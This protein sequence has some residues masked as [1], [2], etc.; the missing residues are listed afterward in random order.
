MKEKIR[1]LLVDDQEL[2]RHRLQSILEP[3]EDMRVVGDCTTAEEVFCETAR[4]R[5]D[6]IVM[7]IQMLG[8]NG[9]EA[10]RHLKRGRLDYDA[11]IIILAESVNYRVEALKAGAASYLLMDKTHAELAR[12]IRDVYWRKRT[13]E[14]RERLEETVELVISPAGKAAR[15]L[16]FICQLEERLNDNCDCA[17]IMHTVGSWNRVS[18]ITI[19]LGKNPPEN[20]LEGLANMADVEKV[21]GEPLA[22]DIFSSHPRQFGTLPRSS[23]SSSKKIHV[24]LK[25]TGTP[26]TDIRDSAQAQWSVV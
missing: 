15:L 11:D 23:I 7:D 8:M 26:S 18:A 2:V 16:R 12:A 9:I 25:E 20:F 17:T 10:T 6:I 21:E 13:P 19:S 14:Y 3:E 4:L 5:P 24:T 22:E 1:V